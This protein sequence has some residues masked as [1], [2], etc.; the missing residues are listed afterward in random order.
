[1]YIITT[2]LYLKMNL[3]FR[4]VK[5]ISTMYIAEGA[6]RQLMACYVQF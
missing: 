2:E 1:M 3:L 5:P 4:K 6:K